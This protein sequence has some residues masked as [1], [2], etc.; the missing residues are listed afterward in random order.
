MSKIFLLTVAVLSFGLFSS[1]PV[2]KAQS[3]Y[4]ERTTVSTSSEATCYRFAGDVARNQSFQNLH[5]NRLEVAGVK[6]GVYVSITCVG[7]G[8]QSALAIVMAVAPN[9]GAAQ[10]VVQL[11]S[12]RIRGV[13]CFDSPC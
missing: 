6:N 10:Q 3:L 4:F 5:S 11:V 8:Q 2:A 7:R 13:H 1:A 9:F 12:D